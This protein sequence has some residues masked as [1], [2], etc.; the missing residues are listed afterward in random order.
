MRLVD[1]NGADHIAGPVAEGLLMNNQC[2]VRP[3][4]T[5]ESVAKVYL[6]EGSGLEATT[7]ADNGG[8]E[9]NLPF[10]ST[11]VL[12]DGADTY[13]FEIGFVEAGSYSIAVT[14]D[15]EADDLVSFIEVQDVVVGTDKAPVQ[16][17][18]GAE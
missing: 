8:A 14:C 17:T 7:L 13:N 3:T 6:Y 16:V 9:A 10:A 4:D 2:G 5:S 15:P 18:F 12:F 11:N 1:N